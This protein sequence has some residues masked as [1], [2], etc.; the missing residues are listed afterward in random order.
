M[1]TNKICGPLCLKRPSLNWALFRMTVQGLNKVLKPLINGKKTLLSY[2]VSQTKVFKT[3]LLRKYE[4]KSG[5]FM[6]N[7]TLK[8][9]LK[10]QNNLRQDKQ[11]SCKTIET[12]ST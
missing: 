9:N 11:L 12:A 6:R 3:N 10:S 7:A 4:R 8:L 1:I 2:T 5:D